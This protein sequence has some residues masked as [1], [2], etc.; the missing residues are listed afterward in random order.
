MERPRLSS[1]SALVIV[2]VVACGGIWLLDVGF[3]QPYVTR[4]RNDA[5]CEWADK[6]QESV[7][8]ALSAET[9]RL[10]TICRAV[11]QTAYS[12]G[13]SGPDM[14][15]QSLVKAVSS[16]GEIDAAWACSRDLPA[17]PARAGQAGGR[18]LHAWP[19]D[20]ELPKAATNRRNSGLAR[21]GSTAALFVR[22][23]VPRRD[24]ESGS[25][26]LLYVARRLS[27]VTLAAIGSAV[28]GDLMVVGA[29]D[30][31]TTGLVDGL[32]DRKVW[33]ARPDRLAVAW[34][35]RDA[36]GGVLG[37]FLAEF[38]IAQ[39]YDQAA[40]RKT[41]LTIL[42]LS[43]GVIILVILGAEILLANPITRLLN[44]VDR[45]ETGEYPSEKELTRRLH[46]EPLALARKLHC[47][48]KSI[49]NLARIDPL[50]G[51]ANRRQF[52]QELQRAYRQA[53]R[54]NHPLSVMVMDI[55]LFKGINDTAGHH[56]G[57]EVL[58]VVGK[59]IRRCCRD[60]D[61][62]ARLGGD[63]FAILLP[64]TLASG[65]EVVA[66]RLRNIL[67]AKPVT[68]NGADVTVTMSIGIADFNAGSI[69]EAEELVVLA[70]RAM[71]GAKQGGRNRFAQAHD[72]SESSW[73]DGRE[74]DR[75]EGLNKKLG[76]LDGQFQE[77]FMRALQETM[78]AL[79]SR[80]P[81][82][83][84]HARKVQH[85]ATLIARRMGLPERITKR[86]E[87]AAMLHDIGMLALPDAIALHPGRLSD[88]QFAVMRRHPL[89]GA[90]ILESAEFLEPIIPAVRC[91]HE[92]LDGGGYPDGL[93][94]KKIPLAA[95][96]IAAADAFDAMTSQRAFRQAMSVREALSEM[97][98][99]SG[100]QFDP[101]VVG[102]LIAE[103]DRL[104]SK[105]TDTSL[106]RLPCGTTE[107]CGEASEDMESSSA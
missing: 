76:A 86:V 67:A 17:S 77:L 88:E 36:V 73:I 81:H 10:S 13:S 105:I 59:T 1:P 35:A 103:A 96:I 8:W 66:E 56:A 75:V 94:G 12:G 87:L 32:C 54:Y 21:L 100:T 69:E 43:G 15:P 64:E 107:S 3:F 47:L 58:K 7:Q 41:I 60:A 78:R 53:R 63:E 95:R 14:S 90:R 55:D 101:P 83:G 22:C 40:A 2:A 49:T 23:N 6:A 99:A 82:M 104:G 65:A 30:L 37:Y 42:W 26:E 4:Q 45:V 62:P 57:D 72:L 11:L 97:G 33:L 79:E 9:S 48:F 70:D 44:R 20:A 93:S 71:Y 61:L 84:D 28:P 102:A 46:A 5:L 51:L 24:R 89:L 38:S 91:H 50:T 29:D 80:D 52:E 98:K 92:R 27:P 31:P 68:V 18:I 19:E 74:S 16:L 39:V 106:S 85:Y 34:P 25:P